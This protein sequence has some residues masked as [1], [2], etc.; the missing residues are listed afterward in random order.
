MLLPSERELFEKTGRQLADAGPFTV[1][2]RR[3]AADKLES[4]K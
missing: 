4:K 1:Q 3:S 2:A